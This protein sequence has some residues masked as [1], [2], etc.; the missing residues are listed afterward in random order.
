MASELK[1]VDKIGGLGK[2]IGEIAAWIEKVQ[3]ILGEFDPTDSV[4]VEVPWDPPPT[5]TP[6]PI[7]TPR[8]L[9]PVSV[10]T[11]TTSLGDLVQT[12]GALHEW[13]ED[14]REMINGPSL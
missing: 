2:D 13:L 8:C 3:E 9:R 10:T 11:P 7:A 12:L 5:A 6:A 14:L 1:L 4:P